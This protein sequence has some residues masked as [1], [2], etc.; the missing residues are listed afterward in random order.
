MEK[1]TVKLYVKGDYLREKAEF[2]IKSFIKKEDV[3]KEII[4]KEFIRLETSTHIVE[5]TSYHTRGHRAHFIIDLTGIEESM[6]TAYYKSTYNRYPTIHA[7]P[8]LLNSNGW[9]FKEESNE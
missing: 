6:D 5:I 4:T 2:F 3:I 7:V 8:Q 9:D 1:V